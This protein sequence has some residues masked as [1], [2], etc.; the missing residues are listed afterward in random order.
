M[1]PKLSC[2]TSIKNC[3]WNMCTRSFRWR[4]DSKTGSWSCET[5]AF[6]QDILQ[7]LKLKHVYP[8]L[9]CEISFN[10]WKLKMWKRS[11]RAR[12]PS[13]AERWSCENKAFVRG[14][15]WQV[16]MWKRRFR[17]RYPSKTES[18]TFYWQSVA[19]TIIAGPIIA[20]AIIAVTFIAATL[21]RLSLQLVVNSW[22]HDIAGVLQE[23]P[24][25][26]DHLQVSIWL[27]GFLGV[28]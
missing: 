18:S 9:S 2:K 21:Q 1:K 25:E 19:L 16:N 8:K 26:V 24:I 14:I 27:N 13:K 3:R 4:H 5:Q 20:G 28:T 12:L 17:A 6:M 22:A 11:F 7:K 10:N 23:L 15:A